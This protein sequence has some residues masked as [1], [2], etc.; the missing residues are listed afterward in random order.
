MKLNTL[1][2]TIMVLALAMIASPA[3]ALNM[4]DIDHLPNVPVVSIV[5]D[6]MPE[7]APCPF[8]ASATDGEY[9]R[10]TAAVAGN[11]V[12]DDPESQDVLYYL[13]GAR[14]SL[15]SEQVLNGT[16]TADTVEEMTKPTPEPS[17][18]FLLLSGA[19]LLAQVKRKRR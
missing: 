4:N 18:L 16:T 13:S 5:F 2:A 11:L 8:D 19:G 14:M 6:E 1:M 17:S 10:P 3:L 9:T 7:D 12:V 15:L